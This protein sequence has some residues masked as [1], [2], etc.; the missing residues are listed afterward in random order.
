MTEL[1]LLQALAR[2]EDSR[3]QFN[4]DATNVEGIAAELA[5]LANSGGGKLFVGISDDGSVSGLNGA[6]VRRLNQ[7]ISNASCQHV[8]PPLHSKIKKIPDLT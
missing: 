2:G 8:R 1:K 5:E 4:R 3:H 6:D 7:L